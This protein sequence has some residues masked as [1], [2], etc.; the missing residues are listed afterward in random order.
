MIGMSPKAI[1]KKM[2]D[3]RFAAAVSRED[4]KICEIYFDIPV[5]DF[6]HILIPDWEAIAPDWKLS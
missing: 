4:M 1:V 2:K 6:L 5:S 3:K